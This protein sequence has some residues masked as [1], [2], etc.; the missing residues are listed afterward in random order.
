MIFNIIPQIFA[1]T[2][3]FIIDFSVRRNFFTFKQNLFI[4]IKP[5]CS[6]VSFTIF[7]NTYEVLFIG[8][9]I[10][11][12]KFCS[13]SVFLE[14]ISTIDRIPNFFII[15]QSKQISLVANKYLPTFLYVNYSIQLI[16]SFT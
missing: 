16:C 4:S 3:D 6:K 13:F 14:M 15:R 11:K 12:T 5:I 1:K 9:Y 7:G 10:N 2:N 8:N